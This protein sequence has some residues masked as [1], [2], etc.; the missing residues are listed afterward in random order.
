MRQI[1][2][3]NRSAQEASLCYYRSAVKK[4]I[5]HSLNSKINVINYRILTWFLWNLKILETQQ[6]IHHL[7][8][9][10]VH[11][12]G[13][14]SASL[15]R[16]VFHFFFLLK[17][18]KMKNCTYISIHSLSSIHCWCTVGAIAASSLFG[19]DARSSAHPTLDSFAHSPL[20][21]LS[22]SV[23]FEWGQ[24]HFQI[25]PETFT[26]IQV[27]A[28]HGQSQSCPETTPWYLGCVL[29]VVVLLKDDLLSQSEVKTVP[30]QVCIQDVYAHCYIHLSL[31][32]D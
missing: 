32:P 24:S 16:K 18:K 3:W 14:H 4:Q 22:G 11:L 26:R 13:I 23:R 10:T 31:Y 2:Q 30:E 8:S 6:H 19:Y 27:W 29:R 15:F 9:F 1:F 7:Q 12:E 20:R 28:T 21:H 5:C 25:S 17:I